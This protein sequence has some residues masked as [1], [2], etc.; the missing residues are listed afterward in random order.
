MPA[1]N[2]YPNAGKLWT[3]EE[4]AT[5]RDLA[6]ADAHPRMI[7]ATLGRTL[8]SVS[9]QAERLGVSLGRSTAARKV[10]RQEARLR[11]ECGG[12]DGRAPDVPK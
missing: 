12:T 2:R 6:N 3:P 1:S 9:S 5:L 7:A 10:D 4:S 11:A 8:A